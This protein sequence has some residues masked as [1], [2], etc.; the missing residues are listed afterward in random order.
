[1]QMTMKAMDT[2]IKDI[3]EAQ[4]GEIATVGEM[5]KKSKQ[6]GAE[7]ER[8]YREMTNSGNVFI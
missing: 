8:L 5:I 2:N 7:N 4:A 3:R 1:M 6:I